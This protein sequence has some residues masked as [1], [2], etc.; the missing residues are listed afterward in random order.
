MSAVLLPS[1]DRRLR[2][3]RW[4]PLVALHGL[5]RGP[6]RGPGLGVAAQV[7]LAVGVLGG[8]AAMSE[9]ECRQA[10]LH[11]SWHEVGL[12]DGLAGQTVALL[13][14]RVKSCAKAAVPVDAARYLAGREQGLQSYCRLEQAASLGLAGQWYQG[15]C[16][17]GM[18]SEFRR[19]FDLG[20]QVYEARQSLD[21]EA[22]RRWSLE[23]ALQSAKSDD[24]KRH[25][26]RLLTDHDF[27]M[28]RARSALQ[29]AQWE[30]D[31][32]NQSMPVVVQPAAAPSH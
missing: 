6:V 1:G 5:V 18:D 17:A 22:R 20:R 7:V 14:E 25:A 3:R 30:L 24:D 12:R 23:Q 26:R 28:M 13:D 32:G 15:V 11:R 31:R 2:Q 10:Q 16:P 9:D 4:L 29:R 19:R 21:A 27:A 8:C